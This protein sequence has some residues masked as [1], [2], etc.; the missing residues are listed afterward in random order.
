MMLTRIVGTIKTAVTRGLAGPKAACK[1]V[2]SGFDSRPRL[3]SKL[4]REMRFA[5]WHPEWRPAW[6]YRGG[7]RLGPFMFFASWTRVEDQERLIFDDQAN[8]WRA[9]LKDAA[10]NKSYEPPQEHIHLARQVI[11]QLKSDVEKYRQQAIEARK[12]LSAEK[13]K[14]A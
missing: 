14:R 10:F 11:H 2:L 9:Y 6:V 4:A 8:F 7:K 12:D 1:A 3:Q 5:R 13:R